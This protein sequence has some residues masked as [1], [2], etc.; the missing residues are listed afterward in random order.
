[1]SA[2]DADAK[3]KEFNAERN[4]EIRKIGIKKI[5]IGAGLI[6]GAGIALY[7]MFRNAG[8]DISYS[9]IKGRAIRASGGIFGG[10]YGLWKFVDGITYL[11]RPKSE[12]ESITEMS[13]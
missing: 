6:I 10:L 9:S 5:F 12:E 1:M 4:T 7:F 11:V 2:T 3:I 8:S 13:E